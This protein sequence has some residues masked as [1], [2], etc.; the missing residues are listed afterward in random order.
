VGGAADVT[1]PGSA[2]DRKRRITEG[3]DSS[4]ESHSDSDESYMSDTA[5][6][7]FP[8]S[9]PIADPNT[10]DVFLSRISE[11]AKLST[12]KKSKFLT[13]PFQDIPDDIKHQR[14]QLQDFYTAWK[15]DKFESSEET[16]DAATSVKSA[17]LKI[18]A[19]INT[20]LK[21]CEKLLSASDN[22]TSS[23]SELSSRF[24]LL[25]NAYP[26]YAPRCHKLAECCFGMATIISQSLSASWKLT[27]GF[28]LS[29]METAIDKIDSDVNNLILAYQKVYFEF[30]NL[31]SKFVAHVTNKKVFEGDPQFSLTYKQPPMESQVMAFTSAV[32][33]DV[34]TA[35]ELSGKVRKLSEGI[36]DPPELKVLSGQ[37]VSERMKELEISGAQYTLKFVHEFFVSFESD[38]RDL[39][40][41]LSY[42]KMD[43]P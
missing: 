37:G 30:H 14:S 4:S 28:T 8:E 15:E 27:H 35:I 26:K 1:E 2:G 23:F 6:R 22:I 13:I 25:A 38:M 9:G 12:S 42:I 10:T 21:N 29:S 33:L 5:G 32:N 16:E 39:C 19:A 31:Y 24:L 36:F 20:G 17:S 11:A 34:D 18:P 7:R 40:R 41:F 43:Y 3:R